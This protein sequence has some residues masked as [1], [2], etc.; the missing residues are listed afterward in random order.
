MKT[1]IKYIEGEGQLPRILRA[2]AL[3]VALSQKE[4]HCFCDANNGS[5]LDAFT[6]EGG[7]GLNVADSGPDGLA[8]KWDVNLEALSKKLDGLTILQKCALVAAFDGFFKQG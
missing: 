5:L 4:F 8:E 1:L 3:D 6:V 2:A 7:F